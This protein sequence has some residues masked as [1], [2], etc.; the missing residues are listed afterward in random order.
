MYWRFRWFLSEFRVNRRPAPRGTAAPGLTRA[1]DPWNPG[2]PAAAS[3]PPAACIPI[4]VPAVPPSFLSRRSVLAGLAASPLVASPLAATP[5]PAA[6]PFPVTIEHALGTTVIAKRPARVAT[7]AWANHEVPLALGVVPVGFARANFG[8]D[9]GDGLL[10]W[11]AARLAELGAGTPVLFDEG[12][13]IDF[14]AVAGSRPDVILAAYSG[15]SQADYDTLSAIA[16]VVA[17]RAGP[18][19]T[20]W[21]EMIRLNAAGLGLA[22]EGEALIARTEAE[23][24]AALARHPALEGRTAM[25]VTH[26]DA[27][28][29]SVIRFYT[30]ADS[31]VKF[32]ADLGLA[33]PR[34]VEAAG[35]EGRYAGEI[36]AERIDDFDDVDILIA[37][38]GEALREAI[39]ANP[40]AGRMKAVQA[41]S[42]VLLG[43]DPVG[44]GA[45]P[46]PLSIPWVLDAYVDR[47]AEA[48]RRAR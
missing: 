8:D 25:F 19:A 29:L 34:A 36:S 40:L 42:V 32:L 24:A 35:A 46:T 31:R 45:N 26:L 4:G 6:G 38:G 43:D 18:W 1:R 37:Y 44:T 5:L 23:I 33:S 30:G 16:P 28:D 9:D 17:W 20:D 15:L 7:V 10:P 27:R 14:E 47:L 41:G 13:G 12:D 11:T 3:Q 2:A 39:Q 48:A 21:R 22:A